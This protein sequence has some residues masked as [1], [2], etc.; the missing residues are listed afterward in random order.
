VLAAVGLYGVIGFLVV[1]RTREFGIRTA[2]GA[3][4]GDVLRLVLRQGGALVAGG[5]AL[6]LLLTVP[7]TRVLEGQLFAVRPTDPGTLLGVGILLLAVGVGAA[8][9]PAW[10]AARTSP[11]VTLRHD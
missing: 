10:R 8:A 11:V 7:L 6:G 9:G 2:L 3:R 5:L 4:P 1:Q